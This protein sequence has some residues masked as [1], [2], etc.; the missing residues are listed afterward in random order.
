[1]QMR[2]LLLTLL[3]FICGGAFGQKE[4]GNLYMNY[5]EGYDDELD[6]T[7]YI[8]LTVSGLTYLWNEYKTEC[9]ADSTRE[10]TYNGHSFPGCYEYDLYMEPIQQRR[11]I[12]ENPD[13]FEY[14]HRQP[15]F[16]GFMEFLNNKYK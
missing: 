4:D 12:C 11:L 13:H 16:E 2:T 15:A 10:H 6:T 14:V 5:F 1:M 7:E 9:Y 8:I 3:L